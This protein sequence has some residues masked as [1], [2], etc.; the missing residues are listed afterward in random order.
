MTASDWQS[1]L[2][3]DYD[4]EPLQLVDQALSLQPPQFVLDRDY[5]TQSLLISTLA[6]RLPSTIP[7]LALFETPLAHAYLAL[8]YTPLRDLL[9]VAGDTWIFSQKMKPPSAFK[10]AQSRLRTWSSSLNAAMATKHACRVLLATLSVPALGPLSPDE[11]LSPEFFDLSNYWILYTSALIC[12]GFGT[13]YSTPNSASGPTTTWDESSTRLTDIDQQI[14]RSSQDAQNK[15]VAYLNAMQDLSYDD[16]LTPRASM[17]GET[18]SVIE[19]VLARLEICGV[20][21]RCGWLVDAISVLKK[22]KGGRRKGNG[23]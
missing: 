18:S 9:A 7:T 2:Q 22:I 8:H 1:T 12:W 23:F 3:A 4:I 5:F 11:S 16:L 17:R 14:L 6:A 19:T 10:D 15:A 21:D 13:R 20:G